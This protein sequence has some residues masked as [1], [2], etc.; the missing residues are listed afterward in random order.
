MSYR[1]NS[2]TVG[3]FLLR[4]IPRIDWDSLTESQAETY[5]AEIRDTC[6]DYYRPKPKQRSSITIDEWASMDISLWERPIIQ[7]LLRPLELGIMKMIDESSYVK[8]YDTVYVGPS[9][10]E[11]LNSWTGQE[12]VRG[13]SHK[14]N[15]EEAVTL[16][17]LSRGAML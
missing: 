2:E 14:Q 11:I 10:F 16:S 7:H 6:R 15:F 5:L 1:R 8:K 3:A 17:Q 4:A 9:K 12:S 13:S